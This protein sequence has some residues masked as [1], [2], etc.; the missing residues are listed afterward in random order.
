M[1]VTGTLNRERNMRK[2]FDQRYIVNLTRHIVGAR[3]LAGITQDYN[4]SNPTT[5]Y[6]LFGPKIR[7]EVRMMTP[8]TLGIICEF[9]WN[10]D[11]AS[12]PGDEFIRKTTLEGIKPNTVDMLNFEGMSGRQILEEVATLT[13]VS[14]A[15]D[16]ARQS[17]YIDHR[18]LAEESL[19]DR[20]MAEY[21]HRGPKAR[22][23]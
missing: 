7:G 8:E 2:R 19:F 10:K 17:T 14:V 18:E 6:L 11:F 4:A 3:I 21:V 16:I 5:L 12:I 9:G 15:V 22:Q 20:G 23:L 1:V 13:I